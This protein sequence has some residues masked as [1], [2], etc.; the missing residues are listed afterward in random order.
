M[1]L[2]EKAKQFWTWFSAPAEDYYQFV[3]GVED[4]NEAFSQLDKM[5]D[6]KLK[7]VGENF[8]DQVDMETEIL[9]GNLGL[10]S[11][12]VLAAKVS[13]AEQGWVFAW[14]V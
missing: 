3:E 12:N 13:G 10:S 9:E 14:R 4:V 6:R 2:K 11:K 8:Y 1:K 7:V 5:S